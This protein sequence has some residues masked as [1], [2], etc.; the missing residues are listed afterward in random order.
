MSEETNHL[1]EKPADNPNPNKQFV[2]EMAT[3]I[4]F[5]TPILN[6]GSYYS[7]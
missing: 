7:L 2:S 6:C 1:T 5:L 3:G 4:H